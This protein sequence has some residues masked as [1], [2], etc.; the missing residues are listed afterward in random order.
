MKVRIGNTLAVDEGTEETLRIGEK[1]YDRKEEDEED[2]DIWVKCDYLLACGV[3]IRASVLSRSMIRMPLAHHAALLFSRLSASGFLE[4]IS[5]DNETD[6]WDFGYGIE[7]R[8]W[9][10]IPLDPLPIRTIR[11]DVADDAPID[12]T[13]IFGMSTLEDSP[14]WDQ[15]GKGLLLFLTHPLILPLFTARFPEDSV[16]FLP[17]IDE[18][19]FHATIARHQEEMSDRELDGTISVRNHTAW[20]LRSDEHVL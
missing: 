4:Q 16:V 17:R 14:E 15:W 5:W 20:T 6:E 3:R 8:T 18:E 10:D 19:F 2:G 11:R 12:M 9:G 1:P 7:D 13:E